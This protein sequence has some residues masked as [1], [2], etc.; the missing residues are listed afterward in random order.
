MKD[1]SSSE[2][3]IDIN[4]IFSN[5]RLGFNDTFESEKSLTIGLDYEK[6]KQKFANIN[7]YFAFKLATVLRDKKNCTK[8]NNY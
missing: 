2:N 7:N 5:N 4:N 1:Y 3:K 8:K 6:E